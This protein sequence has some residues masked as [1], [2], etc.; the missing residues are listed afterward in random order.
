MA[1][2]PHTPSKPADAPTSKAEVSKGVIQSSNASVPPPAKPAAP[3][4]MQR[5]PAPPAQKSTALKASETFAEPQVEATLGIPEPT[6]H[7]PKIAPYRQTVSPVVSDV[8]AQQNVTKQSHADFQAK[9]NAASQK[10]K[11]APKEDIKAAPRES[12]PTPTPRKFTK[13]GCENSMLD[14]QDAEPFNTRVLHDAEETSEMVKPVVTLPT[15]APIT[16]VEFQEA[17]VDTGSEKSD[18]IFGDEID[19]APFGHGTVTPPRT[20][21]TV[22]RSSALDDLDGLQSDQL[23]VQYDLESAETATEREKRDAREYLKKAGE[24]MKRTNP[25]VFDAVRHAIEQLEAKESYQPKIVLRKPTNA[26]SRSI[27]TFNAGKSTSSEPV[28]GE[29]AYRI[30]LPGST[31]ITDLKTRVAS[32]G[33][34]SESFAPDALKSTPINSSSFTVGIRGL[35]SKWVADIFGLPPIEGSLEESLQ[36]LKNYVAPEPKPFDTN[37]K[38]AGEQLRSM[39]RS[40]NAE[41]LDPPMVKASE[42]H[43]SNPSVGSI[44]TTIKDLSQ[45][46]M[47]E[48]DEDVKGRPISKMTGRVRQLSSASRT[49]SPLVGAVARNNTPTANGSVNRPVHIRPQD[50]GAGVCAKELSAKLSVVKAGTK[51]PDNLGNVKESRTSQDGSVSQTN[52]DAKSHSRK[53]NFPAMQVKTANASEEDQKASAGLHSTTGSPLLEAASPSTLSKPLFGSNFSFEMKPNTARDRAATLTDFV[54]ANGIAM[55]RMHTMS[56]S[57]ANASIDA[58]SSLCAD[59]PTKVK[60]NPI[61]SRGLGAS[62][63][64]ALASTSQP[65]VTQKRIDHPTVEAHRECGDRKRIEETPETANVLSD[66]SRVR[67]EELDF[68]ARNAAVKLADDTT[69]DGSNRKSSAE[70]FG[71]RMAATKG[72]ALIADEPIIKATNMKTSVWKDKSDFSKGT[73]ASE[74]NGPYGSIISPN[75]KAF[76]QKTY[77]TN[78][79]PKNFDTAF[80]GKAATETTFDQHALWKQRMMGLMEDH[81]DKPHRQIAD[82][83]KSSLPLDIRAPVFEPVGKTVLVSPKKAPKVPA[84]AS[85]MLSNGTAKSRYATSAAVNPGT[86]DPAATSVANYGNMTRNSIPAVS[87]EAPPSD[88]ADPE[89]TKRRSKSDAASKK[90]VSDQEQ[91]PTNSTEIKGAKPTLGNSTS[92]TQ[93]GKPLLSKGLGASKWSKGPVV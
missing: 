13:A 46:T 37:N 23:L 6:C 21:S 26:E 12:S 36:H 60:T 90:L 3:N 49:P 14:T 33:L 92:G 15:V 85:S 44:D 7:Q 91:G 68:I 84:V 73:F 5:I 48:S 29:P 17:P 61:L 69:T 67:L 74:R 42:S 20:K 64:G 86:A 89:P 70:I 62:K 10:A 54:N 77:N 76:D 35:S 34:D 93:V 79:T 32:G 39:R 65:S 78:I 18:G 8:P 41:Q 82:T 22:V 83:R 27:F 47:S 19:Q 81:A 59:T 2:A 16:P 88:K 25:A 87:Y 28:Q 45:L 66:R 53:D 58:E 40:S 51:S 24:L 31:P 43:R 63:W 4:E 72:T 38:V 52:G 75:R 30:T 11:A 1:K 9:L 56:I 71:E 50:E 55:L 57:V 80:K